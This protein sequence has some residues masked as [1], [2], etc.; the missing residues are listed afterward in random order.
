MLGRSCARKNNYLLHEGLYRGPCHCLV[1]AWHAATSARRNRVV[2]CI[3]FVGLFDGC[4]N[5]V[6][7]FTCACTPTTLRAATY[8]SL[9]VCVTWSVC[10]CVCTCVRCTAQ[11]GRYWH[12][13]DSAA[14]QVSVCHVMSGSLVKTPAG[15]VMRMPGHQC[16][17]ATYV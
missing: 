3:V 12:P 6:R 17:T 7:V 8:P 5:R 15:L 14:G 1:G 13:F 9:C 16:S 11:E 4:G 2:W 10:V